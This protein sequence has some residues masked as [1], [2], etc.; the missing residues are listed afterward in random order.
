MCAH[1]ESESRLP[2]RLSMH[3]ELTPGFRGYNLLNTS[4]AIF[5]LFIFFPATIWSSIVAANCTF[6]VISG[7]KLETAHL[8]Q[9]LYKSRYNTISSS[10]DRRIEIFQ[11][12][13]FIEKDQIFN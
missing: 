3:R 2:D 9:V 12:R 5:L 8:T 13:I 6:F 11:P 7:R 1:M 10:N 4:A